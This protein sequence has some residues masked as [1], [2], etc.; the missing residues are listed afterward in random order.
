MSGE[1]P[2]DLGTP[3]LQIRNL[4]ELNRLKCV[5]VVC[6]LAVVVLS[7]KTTSVITTS[8]ITAIIIIY[9]HYYCYYYDYYYYYYHSGRFRSRVWQSLGLCMYVM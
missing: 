7:E 3:P 6:G 2:V 5:L 9:Y 4:L 1:F 8:I